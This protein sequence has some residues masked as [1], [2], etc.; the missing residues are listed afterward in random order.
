MYEDIK[1]LAK[2]IDVLVEEIKKHKESKKKI[3]KIADKLRERFPNEE[4]YNQKITTFL[5]GKTVGDW[6]SFFDASMNQAFNEIDEKNQ[7]IF[8]QISGIKTLK[9]K[10]ENIFYLTKEQ[11]KSCKAELKIDQEYIERLR[12][13]KKKEEKVVEDYSV[14]EVNHYGKLANQYMAEYSEKAIKFLPEMYENLVHLLRI[15]SVKVLSKTYVSM[16]LFSAVIASIIGFVLVL[17]LTFIFS[18]L[19]IFKIILGLFQ[20]LTAAMVIG[21][22]TLAAFYF[23]PLNKANTIKKQ[24]KNDMPFATIH[25]SSIAGSGAQPISLFVLL[26]ESGE[27]PGLEGDLKKIINYVNLFGYELTTSLRAVALTT[28][29]LKFKELITGM[30]TNM[31]TGGSLK[32]FLAAKASE[33]MMEYNLERKK[34]VAAIST[35]SDVY[36]GALIAGPLLFFVTL[37]IIQMM[38]GSIMGVSAKT[39]AR[40]GTY[41]VLPAL[42]VGF[43]IFINFVQPE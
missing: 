35:Y 40:I 39:L 12:P 5:K 10:Q 41:M 43:V 34:Y 32:S 15:S 19:T 21:I 8:N 18:E 16:M 24:M 7:E 6:T 11:E 2:R 23:Y 1:V 20:S 37:A 26:L 22:L 25:M 3:L 13:K 33:S 27:Y 14:Y 42:N 29:S 4:L 38:G 31:E 17:I 30:V 9:K 28:P 36:T